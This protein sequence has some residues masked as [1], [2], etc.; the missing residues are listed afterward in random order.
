MRGRRLFVALLAGLLLTAPAATQA[1]FTGVVFPPRTVM[2]NMG[3]Q[4]DFG[5]AIPFA[6]LTASLFSSISCTPP[7]GACLDSI[8]GLS[9]TGFLTRTGA[10]AYSFV[11]NP[12]PIASGGTAQ[13]TAAAARGASGLNIESTH[14]TGDAIVSI[15]AT[16]RAEVTSAAF[17]ASR[18]WTLP[19]ANGVNAG[20]TLAIVDEA[21]GVSASNTLVVTRAG[22]DTIVAQG[23]TVTTV[24]LASPGAAILLMSDGSS[25]WLVLA[26]RQAPQVTVLTTGAGTYSTPNGASF[27]T[28]EGAGGGAGGGGSGT[29][30]ATN[31]TA[32]GNT[33]FGTR[34]I[35]G[36]AS[37]SG[38]TPGAG[39]TISGTNLG[40]EASWPGQAGSPAAVTPCTNTGSTAP[41]GNSHYGGA[42]VAGGQGAAGGAA[43]GNTGS[44]GGAAGCAG[45]SV[46]IGGSGGAAAAYRTVITNP[47]A[48]Y[49]YS[50]GAAGAAAA[51]GTSGFAGGAGAP[52]FLV[53]IAYF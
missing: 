38:A 45:V 5:A 50:V 35:G 33:T 25:K 31:G 24:A 23:T 15:A 36:G 18:A 47:A 41:G 53:I 39:G 4:S 48:S 6:V 29:P 11:T 49:G 44:G 8:G 26:I 30:G 16:T 2:G 21:N 34:T 40:T 17:T 42:G 3:T 43:V 19:A 51:A 52:G 32:G 10:G 22:S 9:G 20:Q 12:V 7:S 14:S 28:V 1:P 37:N 27:L 13:T 46:V